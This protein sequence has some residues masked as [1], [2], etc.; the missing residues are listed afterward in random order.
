MIYFDNA[1]T[2][3][4]DERVVKAMEP[5]FRENFANPGSVHNP[6]RTAKKAVDL[7][8]Q[9]AARFLNCDPKN[10]FFTSGGSEANTMVFRGLETT[11]RKKNKTHIIITNGEHESIQRAASWLESRGFSVSR[12]KIANDGTVTAEQVKMALMPETGLVSV[13][14]APNELEGVNPVDDI[15]QLCTEHGILYHIDAVQAAGLFYLD[16]ELHRCD[17]LSVSSHKINGPK[18]CGALYVKLPELLEPQIFG[19]DAQEGGLRG[20]TENVPAIVGFGAACDIITNTCAFWPQRD[21]YYA[22]KEYFATMVFRWLDRV[23]YADCVHRNAAGPNKLLS[24][25]FDG[26]DSETLVLALSAAGVCVSSGSACNSHS[27]EPSHALLASGLTPAQARN[28]VRFS[29]SRYNTIREAEDAAEIVAHCVEAILEG[30]D[31]I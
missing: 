31:G 2:T 28:T 18:G 30:Q 9:Q 7:A 17:F 3:I 24:L 10:V 5:F 6:G 21:Y 15:G 22:L 29:F 1:A 23:G 4:P 27:S 12:L 14:Y 16:P 19:G 11:L 8:R 13:M 20:G 25:R 26:V